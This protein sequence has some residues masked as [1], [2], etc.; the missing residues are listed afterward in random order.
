MS[1]ED[2]AD[3]TTTG[4][5]GAPSPQTAADPHE[6]NVAVRLH[7]GTLLRQVLSLPLAAQQDLLAQQ[8]LRRIR[9][10]AS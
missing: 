5:K 6:G 4:A 3:V 10:P 2:D 1:A 9:S 7:T 8:A